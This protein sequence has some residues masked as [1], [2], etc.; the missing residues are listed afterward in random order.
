M[1]RLCDVFCAVLSRK[2]PHMYHVLRRNVGS[3]SKSSTKFLFRYLTHLEA[4]RLID[5]C[6]PLWVVCER[7]RSLFL[8]PLIAGAWLKMRHLRHACAMRNV[9]RCLTDCRA[10]GQ[11]SAAPISP[12]TPQVSELGLPI[13]RLT[14]KWQMTVERQSSTP[15]VFPSS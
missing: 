9:W 7:E 1:G 11:H 12:T 6:F 15:L 8:F 4:V 13:L 5:V 10:G 3:F 2:V 14:V